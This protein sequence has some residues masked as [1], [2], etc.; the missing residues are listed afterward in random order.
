MCKL[1]GRCLEVA[2]TAAVEELE[3]VEFVEVV[4]ASIAVVVHAVVGIEI[5]LTVLEVGLGHLH[6][7]QV[8]KQ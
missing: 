3:L 8:K 4:V 5:G 1:A 6:I 7:A 2:S